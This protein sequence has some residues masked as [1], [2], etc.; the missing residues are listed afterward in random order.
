MDK[1]NKSLHPTRKNFNLSK[2]IKEFYDNWETYEADM[3]MWEWSLP[4]KVSDF[5]NSNVTLDGK[6]VAEI[7]IGSGLLSKQHGGKDWD[8]YDISETMCE[9][10]ESYYK[11]VRILDIVKD[12]LPEKYD[13][14]ILCGVFAEGLIDASCID[15]IVESLNE[16]GQI[17]T[18][19]PCFTDFRERTGWN[20]Q[21]KLKE[22][23]SVDPE[24]TWTNKGVRKFNEIILWDLA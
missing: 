18:T 1:E 7:G 20:D 22:V 10:S 21:T 19:F 24:Y 2:Q 13:F 3:R 12:P 8:G 6:K 23:T 5:I 11:S 4:N 15:N 17:L 14:I 9:L 16:G